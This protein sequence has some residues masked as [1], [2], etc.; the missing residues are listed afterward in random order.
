MCASCDSKPTTKEAFNLTVLIR[1]D[2]FQAKVNGSE[3][4]EPIPLRDGA[5]D[6]AA[7]ALAAKEMKVAHPD[8]VDVTVSAESNVRLQTLIETIDTLRGDDCKLAG[9]RNGEAAPASCM[10]WQPSVSS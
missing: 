6:F 1:S 4:G 10:F 5:H 8:A 2:G 7:L 9:V 3:S